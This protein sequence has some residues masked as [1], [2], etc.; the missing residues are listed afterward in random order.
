MSLNVK[1]I[2]FG[3]ILLCLVGGVDAMISGL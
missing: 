3:L 1:V 2:I